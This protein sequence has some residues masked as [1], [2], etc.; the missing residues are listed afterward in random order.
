MEK[1]LNKG[2]ASSTRKTAWPPLLSGIIGLV[3]IG[4]L[5]TAV[6]TRSTWRL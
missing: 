4:F 3:A 6:T 1:Q 2:I 5:I